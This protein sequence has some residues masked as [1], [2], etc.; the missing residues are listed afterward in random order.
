MIKQSMPAV[1][2]LDKDSIEDFK[3]ADKVV[4]VAYISADDTES[5]E[6]FTSVAE[7]LRNDFLFG[8]TSDD[9]LTE[10][11]EVKQP[12]IV[13][14]K[15]F[16]EGKNVFDG[17]LEKEEIGQFIKTASVPLI[18]EIGPETYSGYMAVRLPMRIKA[19]TETNIPT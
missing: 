15:S 1:S 10:S 3:T 7:E 2:L 17:K 4:V 19:G 13:L 18:G 12:S 9:E 16:D 11:A 8:A 6:V 5:N 14:Y